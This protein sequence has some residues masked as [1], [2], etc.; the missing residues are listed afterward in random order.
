MP[1][2]QLP[3]NLSRPDPLLEKLRRLHAPLLHRRRVATA[4]AEPVSVPHVP[5]LACRERVRSPAQ[6]LTKALAPEAPAATYSTS[7]L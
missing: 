6:C 5:V 1:Y 4:A 2:A 3:R 7:L